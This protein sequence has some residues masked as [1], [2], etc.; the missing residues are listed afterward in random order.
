MVLQPATIWIGHSTSGCGQVRI[1]AEQS[2]C[3]AESAITE[4][5]IVAMGRGP[6]WYRGVEWQAWEDEADED[7]RAGRY[8]V[9]DSM[10]DFIASLAIE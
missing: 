4:L 6:A 1:V 3:G 8:E 5:A 7:W 10:D 9:F 2:S